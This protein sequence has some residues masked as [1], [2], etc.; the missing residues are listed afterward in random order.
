M[1]AQSSTDCMAT[2]VF[3]ARRATS[4]SRQERFAQYTIRHLMSEA[5]RFIFGLIMLM[6]EMSTK[7]FSI[8]PYKLEEEEALMVNLHPIMI[9]KR[10]EQALPLLRVHECGHVFH[11]LVPGVQVDVTRQELSR[12]GRSLSNYLTTKI[13]GKP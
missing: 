5:H 8:E 4:L 2:Q 1:G 6:D 10:E 7:K 12:D 9:Y 13:I 11:I 3:I